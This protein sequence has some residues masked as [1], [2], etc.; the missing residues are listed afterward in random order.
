MDSRILRGSKLSLRENG[1]NKRNIQS[2]EWKN[3]TVAI[4]YLKNCPSESS[5]S[6]IITPDSQPRRL[7]I[8][9]S[10]SMF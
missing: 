1:N 2:L 3:I 4:E 10:E 7:K 6:S 8:Q 9:S 5:S